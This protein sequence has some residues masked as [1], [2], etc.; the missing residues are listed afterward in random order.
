MNVAVRNNVEPMPRE[1]KRHVRNEAL[2]MYEVTSP[3]DGK[4]WFFT[5]LDG[6]KGV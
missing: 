4:Q 6:G 2:K 3:A 1:V 5:V